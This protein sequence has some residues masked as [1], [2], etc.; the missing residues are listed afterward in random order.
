MLD[1]RTFV[2]AADATRAWCGIG[3][4]D[5]NASYLMPRIARAARELFPKS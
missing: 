3:S 4:V 2:A 5:V 1:A